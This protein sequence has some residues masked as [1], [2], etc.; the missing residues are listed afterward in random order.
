MSLLPGQTA[1]GIEPVPVS[2]IGLFAL[3]GLVVGSFLNVV[4]YRVPLHQS[5]VS[6]RSQCVACGVQIL[7]RDN[8]PI[9]SWLVL[10]G[11]CR[12]C[13]SLISKRY[14]LVELTAGVVFAGAAA[15]IG[16]KWDLPAFLI[17]LSS[18]L[19][20]AIIDFEKLILPKRIVYPSIILTEVFFLLAAAV[21]GEWRRLLVAGLCGVGWFTVFY[22]INAI[23]PRAMGFGDVRLA[24]LLGLGLGWLGLRYVILGFFSAN[25]IG[26]VVGVALIASNRM[27]RNQQIP[28]AVF[29]ALGTALTIFAGPEIL[30]PIQRYL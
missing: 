25:L 1:E 16:L 23:S 14:P 9:V 3:L 11:R 5:V 28:Y 10:K 24:P 18:L 15:R 27:S 20:L 13:H 22:A 30:A 8:I 29:L 26:A 12:N 19:A 17:L 6:P 4:I 7:D 2:L 21:T